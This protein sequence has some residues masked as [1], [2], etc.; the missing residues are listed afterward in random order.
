MTANNV[1]FRSVQDGKTEASASGPRINL[2]VN[3]RSGYSFRLSP[4]EWSALAAFCLDTY[5]FGEIRIGD[6]GS[7]PLLLAKKAKKQQEV[8]TELYYLHTGHRFMAR[9]SQEDA[10]ELFE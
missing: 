6:A 5:P 3:G 8:V 4:P 7:G 1:T 10:R 9:L 2:Q